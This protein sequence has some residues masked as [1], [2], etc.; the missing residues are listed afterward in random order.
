MSS[1]VHC[2][3][4]SDR[5]SGLFR[6]TPRLSTMDCDHGKDTVPSYHEAGVLLQ[7]VPMS[8][9]SNDSADSDHGIAT[10]VLASFG[11][12]TERSF[13][14]DE[15]SYLAYFRDKHPIL[16][17]A[18]RQDM[19]WSLPREMSQSIFDLFVAGENAVY[20]WDWGGTRSG[21][22]QP[23]GAATPINR[24]VINF[25][26]MVQRNLD[27]DRMRSVRF[28]WVQNEDEWWTRWSGQIMMRPLI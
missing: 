27:N 17:V 10:G 12:A 7:S 23:D 20:T 15:S 13:V 16:E 25:D 28:V 22:W 21:S 26:D 1:S 3:T 24:Y 5:F 2:V 14:E 9:E 11:N 18:F 6:L 4:S 8:T 19:W